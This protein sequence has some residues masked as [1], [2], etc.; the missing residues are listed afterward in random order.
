MEVLLYIVG[1]NAAMWLPTM[2]AWLFIVRGGGFARGISLGLWVPVAFF[3][4]L[5][6]SD[7]PMQ[8]RVE[9]LSTIFVGAIIGAVI[10]SLFR[11]RPSPPLPS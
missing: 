2:L 1:E 6:I 11:K 4:I 8:V 3:L 10:G 5:G 9:T 7:K